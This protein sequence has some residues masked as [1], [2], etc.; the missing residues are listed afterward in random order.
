MS[1]RAAVHLLK[2]DVN[3]SDL[4]T[5]PLFQTSLL[6]WAAGTTTGFSATSV[7]CSSGREEVAFLCGKKKTS[8][9]SRCTWQTKRFISVPMKENGRDEARNRLGLLQR[10]Q[11]LSLQ[12]RRHLVTCGGWGTRDKLKWAKRTAKKMMGR[13][14][15][16][17][18]LERWAVF[19]WVKYNSHPKMVQGLFQR[20]QNKQLP[21]AGDRSLHLWQRSAGLQAASPS[22]LNDSLNLQFP[23]YSETADDKVT[24]ILVTLSNTKELQLIS[25]GLG[26]VPISL[27]KFLKGRENA[28]ICYFGNQRPLHLLVGWG[29]FGCWGFQ[30]V[31][32]YIFV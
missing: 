23:S 25:V 30:L 32:F 21:W 14:V 2:W 17:K 24:I 3:T 15:Y 11:D 20:R 18:P 29:F 5:C 6:T 7:L 1:R 9:Y 13:L 22:S 28:S 16:H 8:R 27:F 12:G 19:G 10:E 4:H 31:G 26:F